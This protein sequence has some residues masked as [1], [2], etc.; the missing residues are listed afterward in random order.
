T[1]LIDSTIPIPIPGVWTWVGATVELNPGTPSVETSTVTAFDPGTGTLTVA[2][3]FSAP[4]TAGTPYRV[5]IPEPIQRLG[6]DPESGQ[7]VVLSDYEYAVMAID[8]NDDGSTRLGAVSN[9]A[10]A[11]PADNVAPGAPTGIGCAAQPDGSILVTWTPSADDPTITP[12]GPGWP[13]A[14]DVIGYRVYRDEVSPVVPGGGSPTLV[15]LANEN[16]TGLQSDVLGAGSN[17]I[18]DNTAVLGTTYYY[19]VR[20]VDLTQES[21]NT[22]STTG[23]QAQDTSPPAFSNQSP[24]T[25]APV[26]ANI[27]FRVDDPGSGVDTSSIQISVTINGGT[28]IVVGQ[29]DPGVTITP[30]PGTSAYDVAFDL[31]PAGRN[32][33]PLDNVDVA[34]SASDLS[35]GA[36]NPGTDNWSFQVE[37][38]NTVEGDVQLT[39]DGATPLLVAATIPI[40]MTGPNGTFN[41]TVSTDPG[42]GAGTYTI[43]DVPGG[44][45]N[46]T[47]TLPGTVWTP[48][49][50]TADVPFTGV[51]TLVK[52]PPLPDTLVGTVLTYITGKVTDFLGNPAPGVT[53]TATG[54]DPA[55]VFATTTQ[56][57]GTY[58]ITGLADDTYTVT[59]SLSGFTFNPAS[60]TGLVIASPGG[61]TGVDFEILF[62]ISGRVADAL[63]NG[64]AGVTVTASSA[65]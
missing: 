13:P 11:R 26:D 2:P 34:I 59:P 12:P 37:Q 44:L 36:H 61:H 25:W 15:L 49:G 60:Q 45:Y 9:F 46:I 21:A 20:A 40:T 33:N 28:P 14:G 63:G 50:T 29:G 6:Q 48:P 54:V 35:G 65:V 57:D 56:A 52:G 32:F 16:G 4:V 17:S 24:Q 8:S 42:T 53:I 47:A 58:I 7:P 31:D 38:L 55:N 64:M 23:C 51:N 10:S 30:V 27:E 3:A 39:P 5:F 41:T 18:V 1:T 22:T 62:S 19:L 43:S